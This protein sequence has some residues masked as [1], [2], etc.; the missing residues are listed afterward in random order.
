MY[1]ATRSPGCTGKTRRRGFQSDRAAKSSRTV[2][3]IAIPSPALDV[4]LQLYKFC[5][6]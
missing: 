2:E 4:N 6:G 3:I 5:S 1:Q